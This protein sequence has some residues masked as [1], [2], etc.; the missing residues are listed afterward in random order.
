[1]HCSLDKCSLYKNGSSASHR[2]PGCLAIEAELMVS[3]NVISGACYGSYR[4]HRADAEC[5]GYLWFVQRRVFQWHLTAQHWL[6]HDTQSSSGNV[7]HAVTRPTLA[8]CMQGCNQGCFILS[9]SFL[10]FSLS[11]FA[12]PFP[13]LSPALKW[14]LKSSEG[15]WGS[16]VPLSGGEGHLQ[17]SDTFP[18]L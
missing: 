13:S 17:P 14:P 16:A 8:S 3:V 7:S 18:W 12:C 4:L 1:M 10:S 6:T 15:L 11:Y 5:K 2:L 9:L